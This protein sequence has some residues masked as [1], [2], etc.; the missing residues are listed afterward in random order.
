MRL[1][2]FTIDVDS[3]RHYYDIHGL[4]QPTSAIDPIYTIAMPRFWELI[5]EFGIPATLFLIG[6]DAPEYA[7]YFSPVATGE[8]YSAYSGAS[9]PMR[10]NVAGIPNSFI[11]S[12][13][14]G[15]AIV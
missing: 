1:A 5:K 11:S 15:I 3:L 12:Q 7:E 2:A 14:L 13:N 4:P 6:K 8:K 9:F 10:N